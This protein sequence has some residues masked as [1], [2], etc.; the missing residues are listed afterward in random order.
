M[1]FVVWRSRHRNATEAGE[2][3]ASDESIAIF[4]EQETVMIPASFDYFDQ[5]QLKKH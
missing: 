4:A 1:R 2:T 3:L 5:K